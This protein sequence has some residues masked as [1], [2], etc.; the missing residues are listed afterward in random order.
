MVNII[1]KFFIDE[2]SFWGRGFAQFFSMFRLCSNLIEMI[3]EI[4]SIGRLVLFVSGCAIMLQFVQRPIKILPVPTITKPTKETVISHRVANEGI[5]FALSKEGVSLDQITKIIKSLE[6]VV[7]SLWLKNINMKTKIAECDGKYQFVESYINGMGFK[8]YIRQLKDEVIV[9]WMQKGIC[10]LQKC[11]ITTNSIY[12]SITN[13]VPVPMALE[14]MELLKKSR[15]AGFGLQS[16]V[17]GYQCSSKKGV[18]PKVDFLKVSYSNGKTI[19]L[20]K[21]GDKLYNADEKYAYEDKIVLNKPLHAR[22]SSNY[23]WRMH[24]VLKVR[25]MHRGVDYAAKFGSPIYA[26]APGFISK[27][28]VCNGYGNYVEI[29]HLTN[30]NKITTAYAHLQQLIVKK[31]Q[32]IKQ[33]DVIGYVGNTGVATSAH[34]HYEVKIDGKFVNPHDVKSFYKKLDKDVLVNLKRKI[35]VYSASLKA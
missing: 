18:M 26:V 22:I 33:G 31:N 29:T 24:P 27:S 5:S 12:D 11:A 23:G 7:P 19:N 25:R 3:M 34:L 35:A 17:V 15:C 10:K 6:A 32:K 16:V 28:Q 1:I 21:V 30:K 2:I 20:L 9:E 4:L 14:I 8:V 13:S